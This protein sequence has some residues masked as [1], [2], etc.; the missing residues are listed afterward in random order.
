MPAADRAM[1]RKYCH[2]ALSREPMRVEYFSKTFGRY[3]RVSTFSPAY[4]Q[5]A[6]I[7]EDISD[8]KRAEQA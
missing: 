5:F 1:I 3:M 2:V 7:F 6:S 4:G 8:R